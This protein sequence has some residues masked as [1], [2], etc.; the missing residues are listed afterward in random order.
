MLKQCVPGSL[1]HNRD[2]LM[3]SFNV[4]GGLVLKIDNSDLEIGR[5][6]GAGGFG[7]V[8]RGVWK[9]RKAEVA[10]KTVLMKSKFQDEVSHSL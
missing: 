9:S 6:L 3:T 1:N 5:T 2:Y 4:L 7:V 8:K 10:I